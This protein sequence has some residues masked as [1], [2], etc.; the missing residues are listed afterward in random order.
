MSNM[1]IIGLCVL[2]IT[3]AILDVTAVGSARMVTSVFVI[4]LG[5]S[6]LAYLVTRLIRHG[7]TIVNIIT[8]VLLSVLFILATIT[9]ISMLTT[10]K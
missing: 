3:L 2:A 10:L 1:A 6:M 5:I 4:L 9:A 7:L 8:S